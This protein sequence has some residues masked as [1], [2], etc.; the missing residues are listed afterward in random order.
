MKFFKIEMI[1]FLLLCVLPTVGYGQEK[2]ADS[3]L[4]GEAAQLSPHS[5]NPATPLS[6]EPVLEMK[7]SEDL[8]DELPESPRDELPAGLPD[9]LPDSVEIPETSELPSVSPIVPDDSQS[10]EFSSIIKNFQFSEILSPNSSFL[11][12]GNQIDF[13]SPKAPLLN[14]L[15]DFGKLQK[16]PAPALSNNAEVPASPPPLDISENFEY[17]GQAGFNA[18][19]SNF[20]KATTERD[21]TPEKIARL[22]EDFAL[23]ND[24]FL[25]LGK[26]DYA[27]LP[28]GTAAYFLALRVSADKSHRYF[29]ITLE[30]FLKSTTS[31]REIRQKAL[32]V[33]G[34]S[35][36][37]NLRQIWNEQSFSERKLAIEALETSCAGLRHKESRSGLTK[38][39]TYA[40]QRIWLAASQLD[41]AIYLAYGGSHHSQM[42]TAWENEE[43]FLENLALFLESMDQN[44]PDFTTEQ[45]RENVFSLL[46][47]YFHTLPFFIF[48]LA[49]PPS[50]NNARRLQIFTRLLK[51]T[52]NLKNY[53]L[54]QD[55][56]TLTELFQLNI[57]GHLAA[58]WWFLSDF[59]ECQKHVVQMRN[60]F[61]SIRKNEN[62][63]PSATLFTDFRLSVREALCAAKLADEEETLKR[64]REC[65][66]KSA[67]LFEGPLPNGITIFQS[68]KDLQ[69]LGS[70]IRERMKEPAFLCFQES[71]KI[72]ETLSEKYPELLLDMGFLNQFLNTVTFLWNTAAELGFYPDAEAAL[73]KYEKALSLAEEQQKMILGELSDEMKQNFILRRFTLCHCQR[74]LARKQNDQA[75]IDKIDGRIRELEDEVKKLDILSVKTLFFLQISRKIEEAENCLQNQNADGAR[76]TLEEALEMLETIEESQREIIWFASFMTVGTHYLEQFKDE[77]EKEAFQR[78][79]G[80]CRSGRKNVPENF[81]HYVGEIFLLIYLGTNA[82]YDE[83]A[84][85]LFIEAAETSKVFQKKFPYDARNGMMLVSIDQ[86]LAELVLREENDLAGAKR[87]LTEAEKVFMPIL[88]EYPENFLDI[89]LALSITK[90]RIRLK[91]KKYPEA[92]ALAEKNLEEL[93]SIIQNTEISAKFKILCRENFLLLRIDCLHT[94]AECHLAA[95]RKDEGRKSLEETWKYLDEAIQ[96]EKDSLKQENS[97]FDDLEDNPAEVSHDADAKDENSRKLNWYLKLKVLLTRMSAE[98]EEDGKR[99]ELLRKADEEFEKLPDKEAKLPIYFLF[100]MEAYGPNRDTQKITP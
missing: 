55:T 51:E 35:A 80:I 83:P 74:S 30:N 71:L 37:R 48:D 76:Q 60:C 57:H 96:L 95:G 94:A 7:P 5:K 25:M 44:D 75:K 99:E 85:N 93:Q 26:P 42:E 2:T 50:K 4:V 13:S 9:S 54:P 78:I 70:T 19:L 69:L 52:E 72:L 65:L 24:S 97:V 84:L 11:S 34:L 3:R 61:N 63:D 43:K 68:V 87:Y 62:N 91:E 22:E 81:V 90:M 86:F 41:Q 58:C 1:L 27:R 32:G 23:L 77:K 49:P 31:C 40:D 8:P 20:F 16:S 56:A 28:L 29:L 15:K 66:V 98:L 73:A 12:S 36:A 38:N 14:P 21:L 100:T 46:K 45:S 89:K 92:L 17:F 82:Q 10:S 53:D 59:T 88:K 79:I 64:Y 39:F 18:L 33:I 6:P 67:L 47:E